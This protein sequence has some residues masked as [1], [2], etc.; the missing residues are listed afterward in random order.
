M[1]LL[2]DTNLDRNFHEKNEYPLTSRD[3]NYK[4]YDSPKHQLSKNQKVGSSNEKDR[5]QS[6]CLEPEPTQ[7]NKYLSDNLLKS[8]V[9]YAKNK[10]KEKDKN[11]KKKPDVIINKMYQANIS[12]KDKNIHKE[13]YHFKK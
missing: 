2:S 3:Y 7:N 12:Q 6:L 5:K 4:C 1:N 10:Q 13:Y 11:S 9:G 8:F